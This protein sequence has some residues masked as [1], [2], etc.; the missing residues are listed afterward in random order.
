MKNVLHKIL[1]RTVEKSE[2]DL[3]GCSVCIMNFNISNLCGNVLECLF[4]DSF[5]PQSCRAGT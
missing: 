4:G 1:G 5:D 3:K 2:E